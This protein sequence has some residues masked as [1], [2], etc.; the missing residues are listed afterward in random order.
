M[1]A[2]SNASRK[3]E[4]PYTK[5]GIFRD[6]SKNRYV[7]LMAIPVVAFFLVFCYAPMYGVLIAFQNYKPTLGVLGS[8]WVGL[9]NFVEFFSSYYSWRIIRNTFLINL[10]DLLFA[11][12]A[13]ILLALLLNEVKAQRY[14]R[15]VQTVTYM[16]YFISL[17]VVA[18][19]ILE[20]TSS[21]GFI[22]EIL[23]AL[24]GIEKRSLMGQAQYFRTVFIGSNIWQS[25]GFGSILYMAALSGIDQEQYEAATI[26]GAGRWK[27]MLY[28]TIPGLAPTII[29]M[30]IL[31]IGN[32]M[33][34][35]YEKIILLYNAS[36]YE[37]AD[38]IS[39]F[40]YRKGL[41]EQIYGYSSA[42]GLFNS[43][44]NFSLL[45]IANRFSRKISDTS[46]W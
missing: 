19:L 26:D 39:S 29:I 5:A 30:L 1:A 11:F 24:F 33:N 28:V 37:T 45:L 42:V 3:K 38:V 41:Q 18:S 15:F 6:L 17:V 22:V 14:K 2:T 46:L 4:S 31:R 25:V 23:H 36:T 44:I 35:G 16:P 40:V 8:S 34:V 21:R 20:F 7:Y 27:K 9:Q 12:P 43:V 32:M 10:Y 13:P